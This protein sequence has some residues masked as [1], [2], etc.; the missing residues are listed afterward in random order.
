VA[1]VVALTLVAAACSSGGKSG[2]GTNTAVTPTTAGR[3]QSGGS[4][5]WALPAE[6]SGGWCLPEAQLA[7]SGIQIARAI[8]DGLTQADA[9]EVYRPF[10]AKSVT[11]NTEH[12]V[13]TI[14]LRS[15]VTFH[16]GTPLTA[17]VVKN[18]LDAAPTRT[19]TRC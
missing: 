17:Q 5:T 12:T 1:S 11:S 4:V 3:P 16:D 19:G 10:L 2:G 6:S 14:V 13:W 8:Y 9:N 7:I 18:N 15:G